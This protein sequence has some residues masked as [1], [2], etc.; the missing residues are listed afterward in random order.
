[1]T[2]LQRHERRQKAIEALKAGATRKE[3]AAASGMTYKGIIELAVSYNLP[4]APA[5]KATKTSGTIAVRNSMQRNDHGK[6]PYACA[7]LTVTML[8]GAGLDKEK[9]MAFKCN[10]GQIVITREAKE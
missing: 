1:M 9:R 8:R 10:P 4:V 5:A 3:A 6:Y 2:R 7:V